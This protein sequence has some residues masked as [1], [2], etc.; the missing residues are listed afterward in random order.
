LATQQQAVAL[1]GTSKDIKAIPGLF[2]KGQ[3]RVSQEVLECRQAIDV[4]QQGTREIACQNTDLILTTLSGFSN[5]IDEIKDVC[6]QGARKLDI[7]DIITDRDSKDPLSGQLS[8]VAEDTANRLV[9]R[10]LSE[11]ANA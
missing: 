8:R 7:S 2:R 10:M 6:E 3:D 11:Y 9:V 5:R 1:A 4:F